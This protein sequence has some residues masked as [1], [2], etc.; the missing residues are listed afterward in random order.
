MPPA[1]AA[2][3]IAAAGALGGTALQSRSAGRA[4]KAQEKATADAL[5][6][7]RE[8]EAAR[9]TRY[10][11]AM[12]QRQKAW[13]EWYKRNGEE[14]VKRYGVPGGITIPSATPTK[15]VGLDGRV[16]T[17][18]PRTAQPVPS[19]PPGKSRLSLASFMG[20][21]P[22]QPAGMEAPLVPQAN[23]QPRTLADLMQGEGWADWKR[24]GVGR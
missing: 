24:Y 23:Q 13:E 4:A 6:Y 19:A 8:R 16:V 7:E 14:G 12:A 10:D 1:I 20:G 15:A 21:M 9:K 5:A 11:T 3:G 18:S 22:E 2:A 17:G